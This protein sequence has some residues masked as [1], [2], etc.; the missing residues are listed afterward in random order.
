MGGPEYVH[1]L[2][3]TLQWHRNGLQLGELLANLGPVDSRPAS[4]GELEADE[5]DEEITGQSNAGTHWQG[6]WVETPAVRQGD[7]I[8]IQVSFLSFQL[9]CLLA[10][11]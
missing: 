11:A 8:L 3:R 1:F 10:D 7:Q 5:S 9:F 2:P 6:A 4:D